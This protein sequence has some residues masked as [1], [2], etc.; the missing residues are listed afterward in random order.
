MSWLTLASGL[1]FLALQLH[2]YRRQG[3]LFQ[4]S[5]TSARPTYAVTLPTRLFRTLKVPL[6]AAVFLHLALL[7]SA[8]SAPT[9]RCFLGGALIALCGLALLDRS[10]LALGENFAPCDRGKLPFERVRRG[11]YRLLSHPIYLANLL[12][13]GGMAVQS[14]SWLIA[15]SWT[16]LAV[17]YV[18]S[19]RDEKNAL[20]QIPETSPT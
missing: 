4:T 19:A 17:I 14:F 10:L 16:I 8:A 18:F 20:K 12:I 5:A 2:L 13:F 1:V 6:G 3:R 15:G 11:P 9:W 7:P